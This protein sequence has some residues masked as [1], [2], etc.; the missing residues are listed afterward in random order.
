MT[1]VV[2]PLAA[3]AIVDADGL[4]DCPY[5]GL[6]PYT[7]HDA[8]YFF[9]RDADRDLVVANL[10]ASRLTVL[11]GPSGVGKSSLLRAGVIRDL[12]ETSADTSA[13]FGLRPV[14]AAY[15]AFWRDDPLVGL[16]TALRA[17]LPDQHA[18][19]L[20]PAHTALSVAL[21]RDVTRRLDA[22]VVLVC[23]QFEEVM[24][25]QTG[26]AGDAFA[27]ELG[28]II[29]AS[30]VR[31]A[32]LIGIRDDALAR[33]D[34]FEADIPNLFDNLLRLDHLDLTAARE[35]IEQPVRR[36]NAETPAERHVTVEPELV[37]ELLGE[38]RTGCVSVVE[39][40]RG[41]IGGNVV[42]DAATIE[43]PFLQLVMTRLWSEEAARGS[44]TLRRSTLEELGGAERIVRTHLD[45]V[46]RELSDDQ[47]KVA[48]DIFRHL[49][50]P[51]GMKIACTVEDLAEYAGVADSTRVTE[52]LEQLSAGRER[53]LRP[54]P[55][56]MD[57]PGPPRYEIFHDVMADAVLDWRRR[58]ESERTLMLEGHPRPHQR[59]LGCRV[60]P[61]RQAA[62]LRQR[63]RDR[64]AVGR[65]ERTP[66]RPPADRPHRRRPRRG[67]QSGRHAARHI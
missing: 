54:V 21:L 50:T 25:Y 20:V 67:V 53:V 8:A 32:V 17:A 40:G 65:G 13:Q 29:A 46:M 22:D 45:A 3:S 63:R 44:R 26:A 64:A 12:R 41:G 15:H 5:K 11:Y 66:P 39:A 19:E 58:Y 60:Q 10:M 14:V 55:P 2:P 1:V 27:A 38:L 31:V 35:A 18:A 52:V 51:S 56:P 24:L 42:D 33:L 57:Q 28:R 36:Y 30:D 62:R 34:R 7:E 43:T 9:G 47:Q 23:D 49:V 61:G 48:A 16:A 6:M 59:R 4:L 37:E